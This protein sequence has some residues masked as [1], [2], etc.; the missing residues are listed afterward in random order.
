M[1]RDDVRSEGRSDECNDPGSVHFV[2]YKEM[3]RKVKRRTVEGRD[4]RC[5][6]GRQ[7]PDD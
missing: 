6:R 4:E 1:R 7:E 5:R 2:H 3:N